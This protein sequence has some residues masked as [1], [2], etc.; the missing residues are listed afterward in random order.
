MVAGEKLKFVNVADP[1]RTGSD[2]WLKIS[3]S[4][5]AVASSRSSKSH[6]RYERYEHLQFCEQGDVAGPDKMPPPGLLRLNERTQ[7][8]NVCINFIKPLGSA[9][10]E[11]QK[12]AKDF[13]ER[14]AA[15]CYPVMKK[16][17]LVVMSLEEHESNP[18]FAGRNFNAGE[19][20]QLV[21]KDRAGR[22]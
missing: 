19:C 13:L 3:T 2:E 15:Q 6:V 21:L 11:D 5:R 16:N 20:I 7:R 18:E 1:Q 17:H 22:W 12:I 8:P 14:I 4:P 9:S 10:S